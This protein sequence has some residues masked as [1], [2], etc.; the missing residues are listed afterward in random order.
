MAF[1]VNDTLEL[2]ADIDV[3]NLGFKKGRGI[4]KHD[5]AANCYNENYFESPTVGA[6]ASE[7]GESFTFITQ[8]KTGGRGR[9]ASGGGGGQLHNSGG[10]GGGNG[11]NG[12]NG[13][14]Q[15][16]GCGQTTFDNGG[17]GGTAALY[18]ST[19]N[20]IFLGGGG[21]AGHANNTKGDFDP[22]G[23]N[24]AGVL[25]IS[26]RV[27]KGNNRSII[28]DGQNGAACKIEIGNDY[29]CNEGMGGGGGAGAI[30]IE[31]EQFSNGINILARGG[32][33]AD[34]V[35]T[36]AKNHGTGGGGG[37]GVAWINTMNLPGFVNIDVTGGK[38]G[39]NVANGNNPWGSQPGADGRKLFDLLLQYATTL[40]R[41]NIDSIR[42]TDSLLQCDAI[43]FSGEAFTNTLPVL[44][45][46]WVFGD[47][48]VS[49]QQNVTHV[50]AKP[51]NYQVKLI[52]TDAGY[53]ADS[54]SKNINIP[55]FTVNAGNDTTVCEN[56]S[57]SLNG[58]G[59]TSFAWTPGAYLNDSTVA[60]PSGTVS[61]TTTFFLKSYYSTGCFKTDS[62]VVNV[63]PKPIFS[64]INEQ[65]ICNK[66]SVQLSASG[67]DVFAWSPASSLNNSTISNPL[68]SPGNT[69]VYSVNIFEST[70]KNSTTLTTKVTV[71]PLP[72]VSVTKS[73]DLDCINYSSNLSASGALSYTWSP[74]EGLN[75]PNIGNPVASPIAS[76]VYTVTGK[77]F[78]GCT[79]TASIAL[80]GDFNGEAVLFMPNAFT[81]NGDGRNDCF[82]IKFLATPKEMNFSVYN[83]WGQRIFQSSSTSNCWDGTYKRAPQASGTYIFIIRANTVCGPVEKKG[84]VVLIR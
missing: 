56:T 60:N 17:I 66:S 72:Q 50:Y 35:Q 79:D 39:V 13:G 75:D 48:D 1:I 7:K 27:I 59:G 36:G 9:I 83:R 42:I 30:L 82:G 29:Q 31:T 12:G 20:R 6:G 78:N 62:V 18:T 65:V 70:C 84:T 55:N 47:G 53:C 37:G 54:V 21:G 64:V 58:K 51:G 57:F 74:A 41:K 23:G 46:R 77:G 24:G 81:P 49:T 80:K 40:F 73:N 34:M 32:R 43:A 15:F 67:G 3:S 63:Y 28:A 10:G 69:T 45:Y 76:T 4:N 25:I 33:G 2:N 14:Y 16:E 19:E 44:Q 11:G 5:D 22:D 71:L 68:A 8:P 61:G 52:V 38:N 26:A